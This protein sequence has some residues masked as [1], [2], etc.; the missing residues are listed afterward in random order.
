M[1]I[2]RNLH[3]KIYLTVL[4]VSSALYTHSINAAEW[5]DSVESQSGFSEFAP[6]V[7][8]S[9]YGDNKDKK[10]WRSGRSFNDEDKARYLP[11]TSRNPWKPVG[12]QHYKK[13]FSSRRPWGNVPDRKP[14]RNNN[15]RL[16]DQRFKQWAR[17]M[18]S[19]YQNNNMQSDPFMN[20]G[21]P[22]YPFAGGY[23]YPGLINN[24]ALITP[25]IYPGG[26]SNRPGYGVYPAAF[27][28]YS[29]LSAA[30]WSW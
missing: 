10:Q 18:D 20:Y 27:N 6:P 5:W 21:R 16:H 23:G 2:G 19:S 4:A 9:E 30:P 12:S 11:V 15:M 14:T 26:I 8:F 17:Q 24:S 13:S 22:A 25:E 29:G 3:S 28:P 7:A 1:N